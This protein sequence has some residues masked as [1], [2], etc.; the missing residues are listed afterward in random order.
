MG[1]PCSVACCQTGQMARPDWELSRN[2]VAE[3]SH[4]HVLY[5]PELE[6]L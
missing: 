6:K 5:Q 1:L 4:L 2:A 3:D